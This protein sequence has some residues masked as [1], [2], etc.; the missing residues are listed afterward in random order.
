M[1]ISDLFVKSQYN[2]Y[3]LKT[4]TTQAKSAKEKVDK[5]EKGI[6]Y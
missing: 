2:A 5:N 3:S 4:E 6:D 1:L